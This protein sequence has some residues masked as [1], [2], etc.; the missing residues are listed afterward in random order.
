MN[1][2]KRLLSSFGTLSICFDHSLMHQCFVGLLGSTYG[3]MFDLVS[4]VFYGHD[5]YLE[6]QKVE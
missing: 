1:Q 5:Y 2:F 6:Q 4:E 3:T